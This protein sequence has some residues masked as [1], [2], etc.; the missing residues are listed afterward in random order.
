MTYLNRVDEAVAAIRAR[1]PEVPE[2]AVVLGSGLGDFANRLADATVLPYADL[3]HWPASN[4]VGHAGRLVTGVLAGRRVAALSGRVHV[5]E[6]HDQR[7]VSFAVRVLGRL[8]VKVLILTN[9]AG[10]INAVLKPG[11]LMIIDDHINLLG[12]NPLVGPNED[13]FGARFPD[14]TEVYSTRLRRL[15]D[16]AARAQGLAIGHGVYVALH[17]PSYETPA[18]IRFLRAIG[19]DAVGMS[20]VPEAI[21]ARH[22]GVDVLGISCITNAAAGVLPQPLDHNEV[23]EVARRV[24]DG[25]AALLEG[26][27]GRL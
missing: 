23:M 3:P 13:A 16:E 4:V 5:Y 17:G 15:A 18:E 6:G 21:V 27:I 7:T 2:V 12:S 14:M 9:A 11:T 8:G 1:V 25:F 24:R 22:M 20:T 10:G 26:I 19:A